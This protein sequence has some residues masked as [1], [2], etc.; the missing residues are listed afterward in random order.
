MHFVS[1]LLDQADHLSTLYNLHLASSNFRIRNSHRI[2][3]QRKTRS[4]IRENQK[5]WVYERGTVG[6]LQVDNKEFIYLFIRNIC[7]IK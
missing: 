2:I 5:I 4:D 1:L 6:G 7:K 3:W